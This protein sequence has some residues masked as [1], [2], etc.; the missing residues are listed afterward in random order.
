DLWRLSDFG[1]TAREVAE[2]A[3][4]V[5]V[6]GPFR[7]LSDEGAALARSVALSLRDASRTSDRT[8][9][10]VSGGVYRSRF[11]RDFCNCP[12]ITTFLSD[13]AGCELLPHSMPSQQLYINFA[14]D[15]LTS[16]VDTW[17]AD[18]IGFDYILLLSDPRTF[19]GGQFQF[20]TGTKT[21][22]AR[23]LG[24]GVD[25]LTDATP[26]DLPPQRVVSA[27][28]PAAGYA[29]FQQ[30]NMVMHRATRLA[31]RAERITMVP[32]LIAR[33]TRCPDPTN[34]AVVGWGE[35][36][37]VAEFARHK[38]WLSLTKL[39][40]FVESVRLDAEPAQIREELRRS[41]ADVVSAIAATDGQI[42][43][44]T[45]GDAP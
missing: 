5:A 36:G 12:Q 24:T 32:G 39:G 18:S 45:D 25:Q 26:D 34:D 1:Y 17:H 38:A 30:G 27:A 11:L 6:A 41:I 43:A 44:G 37:L 16:A 3:S 8:A 23:L 14:P 13:I 4:T 35:P 22:A 2:C 21:E 10:Y 31:R 15:E 20:F 9:K 40:E 28:F 7:L 33:E 19:E 29:L 42:P